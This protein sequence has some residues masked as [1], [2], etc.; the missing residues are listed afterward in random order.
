MTVPV[1][2]VAWCGRILSI[3]PRIRLTRSFG[4]RSHSY[5]GYALRLDGGVAGQSGEFSVGIGPTVQAKHELEAGD[6]VSGLAVP[7]AGLR[8]EPAGTATS[9]PVRGSARGGA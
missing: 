2:K 6:Q 4:E 3:Q 7:V 8:L 9:L 1:T 5:L